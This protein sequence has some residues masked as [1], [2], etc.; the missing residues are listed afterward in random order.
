MLSSGR[1]RRQRA[2]PDEICWSIGEAVLHALVDRGLAPLGP[3]VR[4]EAPASQRSGAPDPSIDRKRPGSGWR[5]SEMCGN[6]LL[7]AHNG[8]H[9]MKYLLTGVA[10]IAALAFS[11]PVWAQPANPSGGN[12]LGVPG[13]N[14]GGPGLT[15]YSTATPPPAPAPSGRMPAGGRRTSGERIPSIMPSGSDTTSATAPAYHHARKGS[16]GKMAGQYRG[17]G[18]QLSGS[19]ADQLNQEEL[20]RLQAG[21]FSTPSAPPAPDMSSPA[22]TP[23]GRMPAGGRTTSGGYRQ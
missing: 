20:A 2:R 18:S 22:P 5:F 10:V 9:S 16:H 1:R 23:S 15:P 12:S 4:R 21:N 17:K 8:D 6:V 13:P 19:T 7:N 11:A 14:P 3:G